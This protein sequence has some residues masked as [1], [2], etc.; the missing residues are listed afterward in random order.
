MDRPIRWYDYFTINI[1]WLA[2]T[3]RSQVLTPLIIPL[4]V[5][6]FV[7]EEAKGSYVGLMRL[8][9]LMAAVLIQALVGILSDRSTS[10]LGRRRPF[11]ILGAVGESIIIIL[12][13]LIAGFEGMR[14]YWA[15]FSLYIL[16]MVTSN[17]SQAPT[18]GL[19]PDLV[20][21]EK[22]GIFSGIKVLVELPIP[23]IFVSFVIAKLVS[24][25]NFWGGLISTVVVLIICMLITIMLVPEK[26]LEKVPPPLDWKPFIRL[27]VMTAVFTLIILGVGALVKFGIQLSS[28]MDET[29]AMIFIGISGF[30]GMAFAVALG[31][32]LSIRISIG[33]EIQQN[34][35]FTWWVVNRLAFLV[36]ATNLAGFMVFFLQEKFS[37]YA[38]EKA[39]GPAATIIMFVGIFIL[40]TAVPSGW[41]ADRFGKKI[42]LVISGLLA[43]IGTAIAISAPTLNVLTIGA[44]IIG[45]G[46]GLFYS[47]N[48]ALGTEIVPKDKAGQFLGLSNLAGAGAGAIGAY[49]GGPIADNMSFTLLMCLY[50]GLFL[51]S[52]FALLG[53]KG[54]R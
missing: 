41:L 25:G 24:G 47:S 27:I 21:D 5:Q 20:P 31:V 46:V 29:T 53:I 13:G 52:I 30:L 7:G 4:L 22:K 38:G 50:G 19:I 43:T 2:I 17:T 54:G 11:I 51:L 9:A 23:L 14:G 12:I 48:W 34:P 18:Q 35:S 3:T 28:S 37:E 44:A 6:Q 32:W 1:N 8:W 45:A 16:S 42:L 15:L 40:V 33:Q 36:G 26:R 39:V 10:R 49:I